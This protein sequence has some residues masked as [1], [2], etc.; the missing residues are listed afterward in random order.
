MVRPNNRNLLLQD[1]LDNIISSIM[2]HFYFQSQIPPIKKTIIATINTT[3]QQITQ[4]Y[5]VFD[6][7]LI[8]HLGQ[9]LSLKLNPRNHP[10]INTFLLSGITFFSQETQYFVFSS[11]NFTS[12]AI[13]MDICFQTLFQFC[14]Y[15]QNYIKGCYC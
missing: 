12:L 13:F 14:L 7:N 6:V 11:L 3:R 2:K 10:H 8:P 9:N 15:L 5:L 4:A 1:L